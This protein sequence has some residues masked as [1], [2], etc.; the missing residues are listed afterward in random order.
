VAK[1]DD[2]APLDKVC[3]IACGIPTG[4]GSAV[5]IAKVQPGATVGIW[6]LGT[7]GLA[8]A[9]G[10]RS[11]GASLIVGVDTNPAKFELAR[12]FGCTAF[13]NPLD[14][15]KGQTIVD[16]IK[17]LTNGVGLDV[18]IECI[19]F[20]KTVAD[21]F[22]S[23]ALGFG[24]TV[25]NGVISNGKPIEIEASELL[26]GKTLTGGFQGGFQGKNDLP[27]LVD[28]YM[29]GE[30]MVDEFITGTVKLEQVNE[31]FELLFS[32]KALRTVVTFD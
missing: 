31:A 32:G 18:A 11:R 6:G 14:L 3:L 27:K 20:Q 22:Q 8:A 26:T 24:V 5:N 30:L 23:T 12:K 1:I 19:G 9:C 15:P 2:A 21:A 10:A 29:K 13:I 4:F 28:L 7:I 25:V 17:L 16:A